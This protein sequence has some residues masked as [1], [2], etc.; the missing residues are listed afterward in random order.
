MDSQSR[1]RLKLYALF[2]LIIAW[3]TWGHFNSSIRFSDPYTGNF[4]TIRIVL[5]ALMLVLM[6]LIVS[7]KNQIARR[8]LQWTITVLVVA[9]I[10]RF[11]MVPFEVYSTTDLVRHGLALI[12]YG[13]LIYLLQSQEMTNYIKL[14]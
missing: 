13:Y 14:R 12:I 7:I 2:G 10:I 5:T 8:T 1:T 6:V 3:R 9:T 11:F 4:L